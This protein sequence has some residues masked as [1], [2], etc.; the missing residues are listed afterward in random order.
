M[1]ESNGV[2]IL[3]LTTEKNT[4]VKKIIKY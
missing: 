3:H 1:R 2:Y 4:L